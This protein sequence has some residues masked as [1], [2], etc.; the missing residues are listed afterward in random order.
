MPVIDF[1]L[2]QPGVDLK[3]IALLGDLTWRRT[4]TRG[5]ALRSEFT[6]LI[7]N[8]GNYD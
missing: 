4:C 5:R 8:D 6:A 7:A 3:R 2:K 1:A